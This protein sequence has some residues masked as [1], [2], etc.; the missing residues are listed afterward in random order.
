MKLDKLLNKLNT[1]ALIEGEYL[2][3]LRIYAEDTRK[4]THK[5]NTQLLSN[6]EI[7]NE[8]GKMI[9]QELDN[10][11]LFP[12]F[13]SDFGKNIHI[14]KNVFINSGCK[15]QDQGGIYI[16]DDVLIGHNVV[17]ATLNHDLDVKNRANLFPQ[18]VHIKDSVWIGANV[19]IL[20]GV[21]IGSGA[22]LAAGAVVTRDVK[23][24][25]I[26]GGNPAKLIKEIK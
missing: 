25:T 6:E 15:F 21:T 9:N 13:N 26:V 19:T 11:C 7:A 3:S 1:G 17:I 18:P 4:S 23:A 24:M 2:S 22:I 12:P 8:F 20:P 14:G 16:G 5:I 10:F